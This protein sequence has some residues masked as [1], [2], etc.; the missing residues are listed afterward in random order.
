MYCPYLRG[1]KFDL[2]ALDD[3]AFRAT[4][5]NGGKI[6]PIIEPVSKKRDILKSYRS[7]VTKQIPFIFIANP[8]AKGL[9][10]VEVEADLINGT[11]TG[12][13][14]YF[15]AFLISQQTTLTQVRQFVERF[16]DRKICFIHYSQPG[17][18]DSITPY[19]NGLSIVSYNVFFSQGLTTRYTNSI[20]STGAKRISLVDSFNKQETNA[21]YAN[22]TTEYYSDLHKTFKNS[23][24]DG[25][26]DFS[27]M[28]EAFDDKE[29]GLAR[30]VVIH[31]PYINPEDGSIWIKHFVSDNVVGIE[32]IPGKFIEAYEKLAVFKRA[33]P[34]HVNSLGYF[35]LAQ[36]GDKDEFPSLGPLKK[37]CIMHHIEL[38]YTLL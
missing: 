27:I 32:N 12:Y 34:A 33:D 38:T 25:F 29:G 31:W 4:N 16:S 28:G 8:L 13:E 20:T 18:S 15:L 9:T 36:K 5:Y 30:A 14:N 7:L 11:L 10:A 2:E 37:Y 1:R 21:A 17:E 22:N 19:I 35:F 6:L 24:F 3:L 23:G 26:G